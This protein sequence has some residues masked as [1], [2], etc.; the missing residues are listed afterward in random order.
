MTQITSTKKEF[1]KK[2]HLLESEH[3]SH[4]KE[5]N[6]T[7]HT[8]SEVCKAMLTLSLSFPL[9]QGIHIS[10]SFLSEEQTLYL[11]TASIFS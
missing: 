9:F 4:L 7:P 5:S 3:I 2:T 1:K 10:I 8:T 11:V 6:Y